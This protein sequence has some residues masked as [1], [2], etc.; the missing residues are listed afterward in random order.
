MKM[1]PT[2]LVKELSEVVVEAS[3]KF[4]DH[5]QRT[6]LRPDEQWKNDPE[7]ITEGLVSGDMRNPII[8][9]FLIGVSKATLSNVDQTGIGQ[10]ELS[11]PDTL[12]DFLILTVAKQVIVEEE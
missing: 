3:S 2:E 9:N 7:A 8:E 10:T 11:L 5:F 4:K 6:N 1:M 12:F